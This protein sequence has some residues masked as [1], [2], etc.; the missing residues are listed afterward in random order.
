MTKQLVLG[1]VRS[2]K[3]RMAEQLAED[4]GRDVIYIATAEALDP[5][6]QQRIALHR[7]RRPAHWRDVEEPLYLAAV[8]QEYDRLE[9]LLLVDCLTLWLTN[10]L[11]QENEEFMERQLQGLNS[12]LSRLQGHC[13][14]VSNETSLGISPTGELSR[15][16]ADR[17]GLLNQQMAKLCDRVILVMAGLP[18]VLKGEQL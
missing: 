3:S 14:L 8:L 16:F 5:E 6:M 7:Q 18:Q 9:R 17:A 10:L 11:L 13:I 4:S 12:M 2:G 15:R 1:G